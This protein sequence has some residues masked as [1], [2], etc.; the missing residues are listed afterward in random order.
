M[1]VVSHLFPSERRLQ[2]M[3]S[4]RN[5][6]GGALLALCTAAWV[7][8]PVE[9]R[10]PEL[11]VP[12]QHGCQTDSQAP[13]CQP[14]AVPEQAFAA[15]LEKF[16]LE[17]LRLRDAQAANN[18]TEQQAP[19]PEFCQDVLQLIPC[20]QAPAMSACRLLRLIQIFGSMPPVDA[21]AA[22][23]VEPIA[24]PIMSWG[25]GVTMPPSGPMTDAPVSA[26]PAPCY[27]PR[28][29]FPGM[30][31]CVVPAGWN[32][33]PAPTHIGMMAMP[34]A[35]PVHLSVPPGAPNPDFW[36]QTPEALQ[37]L[38]EARQYYAMAEYYVRTGNIMTAY[39]YYQETHVHSPA[40]RYGQVALHK[41]KQIEMQL[42]GA[43]MPCT[44]G[45][46]AGVDAEPCAGPAH[47]P[48]E[49]EHYLRQLAQ[50]QEMYHIGER[51]RNNGDLDK[52]YACYHETRLL[53]PDSDYA[54]WAA[55]KIQAIEAVRRVLRIIHAIQA[56]DSS[57]EQPTES[58][59]GV[60][61]WS[62]TS[63]A[64][65]DLPMFLPFLPELFGVFEP[66]AQEQT[67]DVPMSDGNDAASPETPVID[68]NFGLFGIKVLHAQ[69][70]HTCRSTETETCQQEQIAR[71]IE[72]SAWLLELVN[73]LGGNTTRVDLDVDNNGS[74]GL[75]VRGG[76]HFGAIGC[77]VICEDGNY[78]IIWPVAHDME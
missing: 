36:L 70:D 72:T 35:G 58:E 17:M 37:E 57:D 56:I 41:L 61:D 71:A 29:P 44:P 49:D 21:S 30:I 32:V 25:E 39:Y 47:I 46:L 64:G 33:G 4:Q 75:R 65:P 43:P 77:E 55:E 67:S 22:P 74:N 76:I 6:C 23:M 60:R 9:A 19:V 20:C 28:M 50:A 11:P 73:L 51:C 1:L 69:P 68:L 27:P 52:A 62:D 45:Q 16:V 10:P 38:A 63:N 78:R 66:S 24:V 7:A 42:V 59:E 34:P 26:C 14:A 53:C 3:V 13:M 12:V 54:Q 31:T 18:D 48:T 5:V 2:F 15:D 40:S 8:A